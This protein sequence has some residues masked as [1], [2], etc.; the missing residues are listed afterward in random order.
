[1]TE[2]LL[3]YATEGLPELDGVVRVVECATPLTF[4]D[5][6]NSPGGAM[7]GTRHVAG[8]PLPLPL[9][10]LGWLYVAGQAVT[11]PGV[12]GAVISAVLACE[13]MLGVST[14]RQELRRCHEQLSA[15]G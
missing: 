4:R 3:A 9:T 1:V 14:V 2:R 13:C 6:A 12:L 11:G 15:S 8:C 7:Y 5:Y 10:R